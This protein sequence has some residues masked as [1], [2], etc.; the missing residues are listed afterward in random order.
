MRKGEKAYLTCS[1]DYAYGK[2]GSPPK[3]PADATLV[4]EVELLGWKSQND[5]T[6]DGGVVKKTLRAVT[7]STAT[8]PATGNDV[9]GTPLGSPSSC[10]TQPY[11][12]PVPH[13]DVTPPRPVPVHCVHGTVHYTIALASGQEVFSTRANGGAP[14]QF[15]VG[16]ASVP[17]AL[18]KVLPTMKVGELVRVAAK[19]A[20]AYGAAGSEAHH[21]VPNTDVVFEVELLEVGLHAHRPHARTCAH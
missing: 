3:I 9:S 16:S 6:G 12:R 5:L 17:A 21:V 1:P 2:S 20:Y 8:Q 15:S 13:S 18:N 7:D 10:R 14:A 4:F 11:A 19:A